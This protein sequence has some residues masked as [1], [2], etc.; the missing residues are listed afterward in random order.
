MDQTALER[1]TSGATLAELASELRETRART[2]RLTEELTADQ[3]MGPKLDIVNPVLWEIGH[4]GWFHE[5]WTL[6]HTHG[7]L[8]LIDRAG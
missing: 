8:P 6:R 3:L 1:P 5:F 7:E 2:L 4:V